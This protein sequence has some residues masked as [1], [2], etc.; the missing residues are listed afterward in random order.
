MCLR[1]LL[2]PPSA[3]RHPHY[4]QN[5]STIVGKVCMATAPKLR[6]DVDI[7]NLLMHSSPEP[8][9]PPAVMG[10]SL[11]EP[12]FPQY[13]EKL[14]NPGPATPPEKRNWTLPLVYRSMRGWLFP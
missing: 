2:Q 7:H 9:K 8:V 14:A 11:P 12:V 3:V 5:D 13:P 4:E 10:L 1:I 6:I